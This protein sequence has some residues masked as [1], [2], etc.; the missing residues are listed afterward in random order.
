[1]KPCDTCAVSQIEYEKIYN[2]YTDDKKYAEEHCIDIYR[3][4]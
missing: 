2:G 3:S 4:E 1:M